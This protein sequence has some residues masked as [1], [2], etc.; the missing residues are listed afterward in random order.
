MTAYMFGARHRVLDHVNIPLS[1]FIAKVCMLLKNNAV[2]SDNT[3]PI[4]DNSNTY[5]VMVFLSR[6][7]F[8]KNK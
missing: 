5:F 6:D 3:N 1:W 4:E 7:N 8:F 2:R